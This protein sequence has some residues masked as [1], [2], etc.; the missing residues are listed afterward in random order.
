MSATFPLVGRAREL[1]ALEQ[2]VGRTA[3]GVGECVLLLGEP[4]IGKSRL[5]DECG[6]RARAQGFT[7][8]WGR[9]WETGGAPEFWPWTQVLRGLVR[10]TDPRRIDA[11]DPPGSPRRQLLARLIP[12]L[13]SEGARSGDAERFELL[14]A[15]AGWLTSLAREPGPAL[16]IGLEDLHAADAA[17][18]ALLEFLAPQIRAARIMIVGT[19]RDGELEAGGTAASLRRIARCSTQMQLPRLGAED[20]RSFL[21]LAFARPLGPAVEQVVE[22]TTEGHPLFLVEAARLLQTLG[23]EAELTQMLPATVRAT[24]EGRL[25]KLSAETRVVLECAALIGR[26]FDLDMLRGAFELERVDRA[27]IEA[28]DAAIV[29]PTTSGAELKTACFRFSH[30]RIPEVIT[31][32]VDPQLRERRHAAIAAYL[33]GR[34]ERVAEL[35][36]HLLRA[37]PGSRERALAACQRA[38][39]TAHRRFA[40]EDASAHLERARA[41]LAELAAELG[42]QR[43]A[44]IAS[45]IDIADGLSLL[46][47]GALEPGRQRCEQA[48]ARAEAHDDGVRM[49]EAALAYGSEF[50]FAHVD[51]RLIAMLEAVLARLPEGRPALEARVLAR[52]AAA[53][54]PAEDPRGPIELALRAITMARESDDEDA[55]ADALR[56]GCSAMVDIHDASV[57][58]ELDR[59]LF[60][61]ARR[62][63]RRVDA[64]RALIRLLFGTFELGRF[65]EAWALVDQ[66]RAMVR[67]FAPQQHAWRL[68]A[69]AGMQAMWTGELE[70]ASVELA[71]VERAAEQVREARTTA[72]FQAVWLAHLRDDRKRLAELAPS[73]RRV[74]GGSRPS[75]VLSRVYYGECLVWLGRH[76][77]LGPLLTEDFIETVMQLYD[78]TAIESLAEMALATAHQPLARALLERYGA[79]SQRFVHAGV[80]GM[81][82]RNSIDYALA[83]AHRTLGDH[84]QAIAGLERAA[85]FATQHGAP[86]LAAQHRALAARWATTASASTTKQTPGPA[87][88]SGPEL[89]RL[90]PSGAVWELEFGDRRATVRASKGV[91][92]IAELIRR[93]GVELHV[94]DL[95]HLDGDRA[96]VDEGDAGEL[97]DAQARDAYRRRAEELAEELAEAQGFNDL[98]RVEH[99]QAELDA[100]A[101]E[102]SRGLGLGGAPRRSSGAAERARVNVRKRLRHAI[103]AITEVHP[104]LGR[105]LDATIRTGTFC[106]YRPL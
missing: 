73:L 14:D 40:Y 42:R 106:E 81:H 5:A 52:L 21:A 51:E 30:I 93:P 48:F 92:M 80:V 70:R 102:L 27:L 35:A 96:R 56:N 26:E 98:A 103:R 3:A 18:L 1:E 89:P 82:L 50:N 62:R 39:A 11:L 91:A 71:A 24:V 38:A 10:A 61:L 87:L 104:E 90:E 4:G 9:C 75:E 65:A 94:L 53:R 83:L 45:D 15:T 76:D 67:E 66:A 63:G 86:A 13:G 64:I 78:R 99:L 41:L 77:E 72:T 8:T 22:A 100:L 17:S 34:D 20:V 84:E 85:A 43:C 88:A 69:L 31:L 97:L 23:P 105:H 58:V 36:H 57:R 74:F 33:E 47:S 25:A 95:V 59:E 44:A 12:E 16:W 55:L 2:I 19:A 54:Q 6:D 37:G 68:H 28:V 29:N 60:E 46:A 7:V 101:A 49:A 32:G 79:G